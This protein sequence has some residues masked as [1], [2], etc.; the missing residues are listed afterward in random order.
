ME[1]Q[2]PV[3]TKFGYEVVWAKTEKYEAK[4]IVFDNA[5]SRTNMISN[6]DKDK[7]WFVN[8]G[9]LKVRWID[10]SEGKV[11]EKQLTESQTFHVPKTM[12]TQIIALTEGCSIT[13]V[14]NYDSNDVKLTI[15]DSSML[16]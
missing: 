11:F 7:S 4:F 15:M 9:S 2:T 8:S 14:S 13:E 12:P 5:N 6:T 3:K 16:G 10:T 1:N